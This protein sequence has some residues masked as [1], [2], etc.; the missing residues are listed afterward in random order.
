MKIHLNGL[1]ITLKKELDDFVVEEVVDFSPLDKGD[2]GVYL[3]K[4]WGT[5]TW[6][7]IGDLKKRL[8]RKKEDVQYAG[9]KDK[10][11]I[12][13]QHITIRHGPKKDIL[14]KNYR[15]TYL[16]QSHIPITRAHLKGNKFLLRV[17]TSVDVCESYIAEQVKLIKKYGFI[18]FFDK[19]RFGSVTE[20]CKF[21]A[22]ELIQKKYKQALFTLLTLTSAF[23]ATKTHDF[24]NCIKN[25]WPNISQCMEL[26]PSKWEKNIVELIKNNSKI[27]NTLAKK[28]LCLVDS[29]YLFF[30]CNVYQSYIWNKIALKFFESMGVK[31]HRF[32]EAP[33]EYGFYEKLEDCHLKKIFPLSLPLPA[34][35][36]SIKEDLVDLYNKVLQEEGISNILAF[37]TRIKG[38]VF[39]SSLRPVVVVPEFFRVE[40]IRPTIWELEFFLTK[41]SYATMLI[42]RLFFFTKGEKCQKR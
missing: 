12:T 34:P 39:K 32:L 15:L 1:T 22:K 36:N 3:L 33:F 37:R 4:K 30:L 14:G 17:R 9:I 31:L 19:Q 26:A 7:V 2:F 21:F 5:N 8:R 35:K 20:E 38:A 18:N 28:A 23:E 40:K 16:G 24:R 27:S 10:N 29:D 42:K 25:N 13:T 11:A 41:G 6:D